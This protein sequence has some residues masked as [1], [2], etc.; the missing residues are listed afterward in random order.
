MINKIKNYIKE[1][2][3]YI[4]VMFLGII[5][6]ALQMR[7]VV[8]YADDFGEMFVTKGK[9]IGAAFS[10]YAEYYMTWGGGLNVLIIYIFLMF[11]ISVWKIFNC[12]MIFVIVA[13][14]VR[15]ISYKT[16]INKA[17][18]ALVFWISLYALNILI[19]REVIYWVSGNLS[20]ILPI[21]QTIIYFY[22]LYSRLIMKTSP[23]KYDYIL[24]P[25]SA[26]WAGWSSP[27]SGATIFV[28][29]LLLVLWVRFIKKEKINKIYSLSVFFCLIGYMIL[30]LA[31]GNYARMDAFEEYSSLGI[32]D[33]ILY[34]IDNIF[35]ILFEF[36]KG[37]EIGRVSFYLFITIG[38][39]SIIAL[40][41]VKDEKNNVI[42]KLIK[43]TSY[44][45]LSFIALNF[46][47][48]IDFVNSTVIT[49]KLFTYRNLYKE[50]T[51]NTFELQMIVPYIFGIMVI[52]SSI[53]SSIYISVKK[54]DPFLVLMMITAF[55]SQIVMLMAPASEHRTMYI[56][57]IH[58]TLAI[59]YLVKI[60][61]EENISVYSIFILILA[62]CNIQL[63]LIALIGY[64]ILNNINTENR[65]KCELV[66]IAFIIG[67][68]CY[69]QYVQVVENYRLNKIIYNSN[70]AR[71]EKFKEQDETN[72]LYLLNPLTAEYG[73]TPL[74]GIEWI[75]ND[76]K[77]YFGLDE[78][79]E[80][81][82][83]NITKEALLGRE[84]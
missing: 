62:I 69:T 44:I 67:S 77:E 65:V 72:K 8:Y 49:E 9:G 78:D 4:A 3:L 24:L 63:G 18:L 37:Y 29:T 79:V 52:L 80:F 22:Y 6:F 58:C 57:I 23:K 39:I 35:K 45:V 13:L 1:N 27:Q 10:K 40:K 59:M 74:V 26:I 38:I 30:Y 50:I 16:K 42:Q 75:Q 15:M 19:S 53:I 34:R 68:L 54:K 60:I 2:K 71:I 25:L 61:R 33:R 20:Y 47:S 7:Y 5:A 51:K 31:P 56:A 55:L 17:M 66:V 32:W 46:I 64:I 48:K 12:F 84:N 14:A 28:I 82:E 70:I 11:D 21:F 73:F 83:E 43:S 41:F 36:V 81:L 76:L